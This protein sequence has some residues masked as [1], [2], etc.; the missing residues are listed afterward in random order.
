MRALAIFSAA[1]GWC[2]A[3]VAWAQSTS[4]DIFPEEVVLSGQVSPAESQSALEGDL[5]LRENSPAESAR[6]WREQDGALNV[7]GR[8]GGRSRFILWTS[9]NLAG[10]AI[11]N[12][13]RDLHGEPALGP[14]VSGMRRHA[15]VDSADDPAVRHW[16]HSG[17]ASPHGL[18]VGY[19]WR[20]VQ[21]EGSAFA[22]HLPEDRISPVADSLKLD[23]R[24]ARLTFKPSEKWSFQFSKGTIGAH[25]QI[26]SG[27]DIRRTTLS[28]TY[29]HSFDL[30]EWESTLA[31]GRNARRARE[32]TVGYL[33]ESSLRFQHAHIVF[34]RIERVGSDELLRQNESFQRT[35]FKLSKLTVG[36]YQDL[37]ATPAL[38]MDVGLLVSRYLVPS[39]VTPSYGNDPTTCM[40]FVRLKF[41]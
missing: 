7:L 2:A 23:S 28:S 35:P 40:A 18:T 10:A 38:S 30:G 25:D 4:T 26:V 27:G 17:G 36:Y 12:F 13:G 37:R 19:A 11:P 22:G 15:G 32:T 8:A 6:Y 3:S 24:S 5:A 34:G 1:V 31:W 20:D 41:H 9:E 33:L 39:H 29:R 14:P 21:V 16:L